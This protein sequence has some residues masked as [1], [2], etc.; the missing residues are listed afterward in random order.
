[1]PAKFLSLIAA[2]GLVAA[3]LPAQAQTPGSW[4]VGS[5][6]VIRYQH[7]DLDRAADRQ[8]LL[9]QVERAAA[10]LCKDELT[11]SRRATCSAAAIDQSLKAT[12][13]TV[14]Q[15]VQTAL[16]ERNGIQQAQR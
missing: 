6:Y 9:V 2:A 3:S 13:A 16:L 4:K 8:A 15:A 10:K 1:M 7:L 5:D 11:A 14:Q 12:P